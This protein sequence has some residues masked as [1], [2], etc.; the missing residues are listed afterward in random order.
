MLTFPVTI[1]GESHWAYP[2][3]PLNFGVKVGEAASP[4]SYESQ[5]TSLVDAMEAKDILSYLKNEANVRN[6]V[7]YASTDGHPIITDLKPE[8]LS[9]KTSH[10]MNLLQAYLL[11]KPWREI[12]PYV[13]DSVG[14]FLSMVG[15]LESKIVGANEG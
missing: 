7:L 12:Q 6:K 3:P 15:A 8:F 2:I 4:P 5:I 9:D 13:Q 14:A 1:N 11:I 10:V